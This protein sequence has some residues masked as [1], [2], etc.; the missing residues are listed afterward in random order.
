[1]NLPRIS[2]LIWCCFPFFVSAQVIREKIEEKRAAITE[3]L[4]DTTGSPSFL[5]YPTLAYTPE[6]RLEVGLVNL[7]LYYA[8]ND[9][10]NRLSEINTFTFYTLA[11]QFGIWADHALY[12]H[13]DRWFFL[14]KE[15][16]QYFPLKYFGIGIHA[17]DSAY[18]VVNNSSI[19]LRERVLHK[20]HGDLYAG[21]EFDYHRLYNVDFGSEGPHHTGLPPGGIGSSNIGLGAGL[22]YDTR[23]NV[24]NVRTG[25]FAELAYLNYNQYWTSDYQ[26]QSIQL[27]GR[28]FHKG[29]RKEQ[30][31]AVQGIIQ[32]NIGNVPFNQMALMGGETIMR[33]YYQG[34]FRDRNQLAVQAEYRFL[35]LPFSKR[36]GATLFASGGTVSSKPIELFQNK[37]KLAG[38]AGVR[39]LIFPSKDI[40][41]RLDL[42]FTQEGPGYYL[43][44]GEAF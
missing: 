22:V 27:D 37:Y 26:F 36:F 33:G 40:F 12:G 31:W 21:L 6:T 44:I 39:Y 32:A 41:V 24:M 42:A 8:R 13:R 9:T 2:I 20:V 35:P 1:M 4:S 14:G 29:L 25:L 15:R 16:L 11:G 10:R 38:G 28:Y 7:F 23:R 18:K 30:V 43:F 34:R 5:V 19:Q 17:T 3:K